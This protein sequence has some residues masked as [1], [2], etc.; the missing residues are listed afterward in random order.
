MP[1]EFVESERISE[2]EV[3][4]IIVKKIH[5]SGFGILKNVNQF[6][7]DDELKAHE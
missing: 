5:K 1:E 4:K 3:V 6:T 2:G 7:V